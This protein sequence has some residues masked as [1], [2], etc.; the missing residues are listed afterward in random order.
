MLWFHSSRKSVYHDVYFVP[1]LNC[2]RTN[3]LLG[4]NKISCS[5][6]HGCADFCKKKGYQM[7]GGRK[8]SHCGSKHNKRYGSTGLLSDK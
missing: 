3:I 2:P 4:K 7:Q 8:Y 5:S 1:A 6:L